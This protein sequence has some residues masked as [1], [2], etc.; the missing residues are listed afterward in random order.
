MLYILFVE[1]CY[2][3][4]TN[5]LSFSDAVGSSYNSCWLCGHS[6]Y[7]CSIYFYS[8]QLTTS[9]SRSRV[10]SYHRMLNFYLMKTYLTVMEEKLLCQKGDKIP[11]F[12]FIILHE[13][14]VVPSV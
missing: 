6:I 4:N 8:C 5:S 13:T 1:H 12:F 2:H 9:H 10:V 14:N 7:N 11:P 3:T